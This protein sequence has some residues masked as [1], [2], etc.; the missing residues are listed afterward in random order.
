MAVVPPFMKVPLQQQKENFHQ[1]NDLE[2]ARIRSG[3]RLPEESDWSV[4]DGINK[5]NAKRN[6]YTNVF[7]YDIS[8]VKL[9]LNEDAT[10]TD[11]INASYV[12]LYKS[13]YIAAQ[14]PLEATV[15]Q[16]W[17]M[18][19]NE[20][21]KQNNEVILI[22]MVTPLTESGMVKCNRYWPDKD[23]KV[24]EM[25][26]ENKQDGIDISG[27]TLEHVSE[28]Y[29]EI[30]DF[31]LTEMNLKSSSKSKK[32]Y[33]F[34][35]YKWA[36]SRVPASIYPLLYLSE[37]IN[38]IRKLVENPPIPI[39][40]CS[41]GV[42]RTGTF[43]AIDHLF[44]DFDKFIAVCDKAK[45]SKGYDIDF[46]PVFQTVLQLR[47]SRMMMVQTAYQFSFLYESAKKLYK[48]RFK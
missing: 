21:E 22:V 25:A 9:P 26:A 27:L 32:V 42:G 1:L 11:Y 31:L 15:N 45:S 19:Y 35:Y 34:Y 8:R 44:R 24:L 46:D 18:A 16:F 20:S 5:A 33:H 6:R 41:A 40:H 36:D 4:A 29:D 28:T 14:G 37:E 23:Q 17:S 38:S 39:V 2:A 3:L 43:I 12:K 47:D 13:T 30:G 48:E 7:P 10:G